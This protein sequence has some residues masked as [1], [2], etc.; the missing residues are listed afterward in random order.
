MLQRIQIEP[1]RRH[2]EG[3]VARW[4]PQGSLLEG[5]R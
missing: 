5:Y 2:L 4:V 1:V 3:L